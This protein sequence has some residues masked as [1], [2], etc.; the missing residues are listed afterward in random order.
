MSLN[1]LKRGMELSGKKYHEAI[2]QRDLKKAKEYYSAYSDFKRQYECGLK[3]IRAKQFQENREYLDNITK[4]HK[5]MK[6]M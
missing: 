3:D 1:E 4:H 2:R 6:D 5:R